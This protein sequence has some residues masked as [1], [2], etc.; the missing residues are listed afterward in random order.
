MQRQTILCLFMIWSVLNVEYYELSKKQPFI[1]D[2]H[3]VAKVNFFPKKEFTPVGC[4]KFCQSMG[5]RSPPLRTNEELNETYAMF[6]DLMEFSPSPRFMFL[7]VTRG[8]S[9]D[10]KDHL[11]LDHWPENVREEKDGLWRDYYTA[12]WC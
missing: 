7:S 1:Y 9:D 6:A 11:T 3:G 8:E 5:G 4:M 10:A 12:L 2:H